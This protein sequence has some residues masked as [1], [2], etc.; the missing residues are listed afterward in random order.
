[1]S[2]QRVL[3]AIMFTDIVRRIYHNSPLEKGEQNGVV[4]LRNI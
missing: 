3:A 2:Q 1:M 4:C